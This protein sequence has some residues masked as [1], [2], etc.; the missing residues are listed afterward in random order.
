MKKFNMLPEVERLLKTGSARLKRNSLSLRNKNLTPK[1]KWWVVCSRYTHDQKWVEKHKEALSCTQ[2][3]AE[4]MIGYENAGT[5]NDYVLNVLMCDFKSNPTYARAQEI[6]LYCRS[7]NIIVPKEVDNEIATRFALDYQNWIKPGNNLTLLQ[8]QR[9]SV[10][11]TDRVSKEAFDIL[12]A[13][14]N[15]IREHNCSKEKAISEVYKKINIESQK[16]VS[17]EAFEKKARRAVKAFQQGKFKDSLT[18]HKII[19]YGSNEPGAE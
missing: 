12:I 9:E 7:E 19:D 1:S 15:Y 17:W 13:V 16:E 10:W 14:L 11:K 3:P 8:I 5:T 2:T 4:I 6:W 18:S